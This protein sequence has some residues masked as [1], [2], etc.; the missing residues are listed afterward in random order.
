MAY[1]LPTVQLTFKVT[2]PVGGAE[3]V[4]A[5]APVPL[6]DLA[7]SDFEQPGNRQTAARANAATMI[8]VSLFME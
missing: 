1:S 5:P 7:L 2:G 8:L 3:A 4:S 6:P